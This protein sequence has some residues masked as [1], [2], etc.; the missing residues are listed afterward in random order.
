MS[1][2]A[3]YWPVAVALVALVSWAS[4]GVYKAERA[5]SGNVEQWKR[6]SEL[7]RRLDE[8]EKQ[9]AILEWK[10]ANSR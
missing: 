10:F 8:A 1:W 2:V 5:D 9:I 4:L 7:D 6:I 3:K